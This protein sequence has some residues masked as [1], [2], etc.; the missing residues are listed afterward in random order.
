MAQSTS[1]TRKLT[2]N[3]LSI[4][5]EALFE[6]RA[7]WEDIGIELLSKNDTDAIKKEKDNV[8]DCL[9]E[10]LSV[11][12]KRS[13]PEPSW[14]SI[15]AAL[16]ARA[17][18]FGQLA[19]NLE[20]QY[21]AVVTS[22]QE[23]SQ[24]SF[25]GIPRTSSEDLHQQAYNDFRRMKLAFSSL[26]T[27]I[28]RKIKRHSISDFRAHV[29]GMGILDEDDETYV[30]GADD[31][32][33]IFAEV[34]M[35]Y[36][37]FLDYDNFDNI[38]KNMCESDPEQIQEW[39]QYKIEIKRFCERC[40]VSELPDGFLQDSNAKYDGMEKVVVKLVL[41]DPVLKRI[42]DCKRVIANILDIPSSSL[43]LCNIE[44]GCILISFMI[45]ASLGKKVFV[46][47]SLTEDQK[48][49]LKEAGV[50]SMG[51]NDKSTLIMDAPFNHKRKFLLILLPSSWSALIY[52]IQWKCAYYPGCG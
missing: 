50:L 17:V 4:V 29:V 25:V 26:Q 3:S 41:D 7:K 32:D 15:I 23:L 28:R 52:G 40:R 30:K 27:K 31:I 39:L 43:I 36:W 51:Y 22:E 46:K 24:I 9:T 47:K 49:A 2:P 38:V 6:A 42:M 18:G 10:M 11:Y 1:G 45:A 33:E 48:G 5:R 37:S 13:N 20:Q 21:C 44:D 16:R 12:L 34:L 19:Q 14:S 8:I 35:K